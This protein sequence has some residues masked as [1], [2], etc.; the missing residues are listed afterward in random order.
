MAE[1]KFKGHV[2]AHSISYEVHQNV[3]NS[4]KTKGRIDMQNYVLHQWG[5]LVSTFHFSFLLKKTKTNGKILI[6]N[7]RPFFWY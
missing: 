5:K 4:S 6:L 2:S 3:Y 1:G 7:Y